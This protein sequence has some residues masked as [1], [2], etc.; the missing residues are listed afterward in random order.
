M[1]EP[2]KLIV[3]LGNPGLKYMNSRHNVGWMIVDKLAD[4]IGVSFSG[5]KF[6]GTIASTPYGIF[7]L[8][9]MTFMNLSGESVKKAA[10]FY[11]LQ[12]KQILVVHDD[13]DM[14]IGKLRLKFNS[15]SGGHKGVES[16]QE[17]LKSKVFPRLKVGIGRPISGESIADYVLSPFGEEKVAIEDA[18]DRA[19][20]CLLLILKNGTIDQ[21][22]LSRCNQGG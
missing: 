2:I 5:D 18:I 12:P 21:K 11:K 10:D 9:P 1:P 19:V 3:G 4:T 13:I 8:K 14:A 15:S 17:N 6:K 20:D 7:L 16:I 22:I